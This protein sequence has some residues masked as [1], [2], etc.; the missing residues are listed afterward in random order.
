MEKVNIH[1]KLGM[2]GGPTKA[3][4]LRRVRTRNRGGEELLK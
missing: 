2:A 1:I 4:I 3:E